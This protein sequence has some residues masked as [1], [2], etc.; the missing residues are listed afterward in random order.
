MKHLVLLYFI[1]GLMISCGNKQ[2]GSGQKVKAETPSALKDNSLDI[3]YIPNF[4][5]Q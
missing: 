3:S 2:Q 4:V 1:C 5:P